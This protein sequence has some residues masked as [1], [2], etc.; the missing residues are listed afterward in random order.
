MRTMQILLLAAVLLALPWTAALAGDDAPAENETRVTLGMWHVEEDGSP[1]KVQ[2]YMPDGYGPDIGVKMDAAGEGAHFLLDAHTLGGTTYDIRM[3]FDVKR[4]LRSHTTYLKLPHRLPHDPMDNLWSVTAPKVVMNTDMD[5]QGEY[6]IQFDQMKST[7]EFQHPG[8]DT[9]TL[10]ITV[11]HQRRKGTVQSLTVSH[12]YNCH[13][14]S[15]PQSVHELVDEFGLFADFAFSEGTFGI[16]YDHRELKQERDAITN[17]YSVVQHPALRTPIFTNRMSYGA[18]AGH[19]PAHV[20]PEYEKRT[21]RL[22]VNLPDLRGFTLDFEGVFSRTENQ[23]TN[24]ESKYQGF[25]FNAARRLGKKWTFRLRTHAYDLENDEVYVDIAEPATPAGPQAGLTFRDVYG[26]NPDF[27]RYSSL[28]RNVFRSGLDARYRIGKRAGSVSF[29]WNYEKVDRDHFTVLDGSRKTTTNEFYA[30]W[31]AR[32]WKGGN[33]RAR[34][35]VTDTSHAFGNPGGACTTLTGGP[36]ASPFAGIQY[37]QMYDARVAEP[38][39]SPERVNEFKV[40]VSHNFGARAML[41]G[42]VNW[43][44]GDN[45][46]GYMTDWSKDRT[47]ANLSFWHAPAEIMDWYANYSY[48]KVKLDLPVCIALMDG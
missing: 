27:R 34:Y 46:E 17:L 16:R 11:G 23:R 40:S 48:Q 8:F 26:F 2:E 29:G 6:G 4:M 28:D 10:G 41:T 14:T 43:W 39:A 45:D 38:T 1:D 25:R 42:S 24:L 32:P 15:Q 22:D 47:T 33:V 9:M 19:T 13:V 35:E 7:L 44:S 37:F 5:P 3:D 21:T 30:A 12:C 31:R 20:M 18:E 36:W